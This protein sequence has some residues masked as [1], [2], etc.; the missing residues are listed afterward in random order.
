MAVIQQ[1]VWFLFPVWHNFALL[2]NNI[3]I[4][5]L[6]EIWKFI[7]RYLALKRICVIAFLLFALVLISVAPIPA[8]AFWDIA[9]KTYAPGNFFQQVFS[10]VQTTSFSN[11]SA[12]LRLRKI[13]NFKRIEMFLSPLIF[14]PLTR[15]ATL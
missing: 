9:D 12:I 15:T 5:S 11:Q 4:Q 13:W 8:T 14:L 10:V 6:N 3:S 1:A 2:A 7:R